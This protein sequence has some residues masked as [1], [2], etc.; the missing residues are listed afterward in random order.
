MIP[1]HVPMRIVFAT[2]L[3]VISIRYLI[4]LIISFQFMEKLLF[5]LIASI[6]L[7]SCKSVGVRVQGHST[8]LRSDTIRT[9]YEVSKPLNQAID[10]NY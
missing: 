10:I 1:S 6:S 4:V 7:A 8:I 9:S 3:L 2:V 5:L